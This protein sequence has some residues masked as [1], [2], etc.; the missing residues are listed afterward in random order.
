ML[1]IEI[2][3]TQRWFYILNKKEDTEAKDVNGFRKRN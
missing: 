1:F 3:E 2:Q